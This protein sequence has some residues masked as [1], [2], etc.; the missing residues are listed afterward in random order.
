MKLGLFMLVFI[1]FQMTFAQQ[2]VLFKD[3]TVHV[4]NGAKINKG[5]VGVEGDEIVLM[6]NALTYTIDESD[7]DT[8]IDISG[9]HV[10][11]AFFALNST[12]GL[13]EIDAV[14]ATNDFQEVGV[15]NPHVR[16]LIAFNAE[17]EV[18]S[19]VK[20]NGVLY[21][22]ATPKGGIISGSSSLMELEAWNW[23][24]AVVKKDEGLHLHW[25]S[26]LQGGGWWAE[27]KPKEKNK[28]YGSNVKRIH[29]FF[30]AAQSYSDKSG[31]FDQRFEA[32]KTLFSGEQR[33]Y[34]HANELKALIDVIDFIETF[35]IQHPVIIGG[36]DAPL[37]VREL[38]DHNIPVILKGGHSL[39]RNDDDPVDLP[40]RL[41]KILSDAGILFSIQHA[42]GMEA[43]NSRNIPFL[44][45]T[46][47][48]YG[49]SEEEAV[50]AVSLNAA[51]IL[52]LE[53]QL[54]SLEKGKIAS[55]FVSE[56]N[57]LDMRTNRV[58]VAMIAGQFINLNNRQL[59]LYE[60]YKAK[61]DEQKK[62]QS[63]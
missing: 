53:D 36:Y 21:A 33:L 51:R 27:P 13:T 55:L 1:A 48:A 8:I 7:W 42:G 47:M 18:S 26:T 32:M 22:Q 9:K 24:D 6:T 54:G 2:K 45:G 23:E 4:G 46:A 57:A 39:P 41:P 61:Y 52:G 35:D 30:S 59:E 40:Y 16:A 17:S 37:V 15:F 43:M 49:L 62:K 38:R 5:L 20:T 28:N 56:G 3:G 14:R 34:F 50:A 58:V 25:P 10:Y 44:A 29:D 11:P 60:R 63:P 12:L 31:E 19:T